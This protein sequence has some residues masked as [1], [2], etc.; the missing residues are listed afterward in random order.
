MKFCSSPSPIITLNFVSIN[1]RNE[2]DSSIIAVRDP[3][4]EELSEDFEIS[5][6]HAS[7]GGKFEPIIA[8]VIPFYSE[9]LL[10]MLKACGARSVV[11]NAVSFSVNPKTN[12]PMLSEKE[13]GDGYQRISWKT[14]VQITL[15]CS[16]WRRNA[17]SLAGEL[18]TGCVFSSFFFCSFDAVKR[19]TSLTLNLHTRC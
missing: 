1:P 6:Y 19:S 15:L 9:F 10:K 16:Y 11:L 5:F 7:I 8:S 14:I 17:A 3:P 4:N 2:V 13:Q 12:I 18:T